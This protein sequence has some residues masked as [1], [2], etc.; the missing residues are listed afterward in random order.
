MSNECTRDQ[1]PFNGQMRTGTGPTLVYSIHDHY[2]C[3]I[4]NTSEMG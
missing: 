2:K 3:E 1:Y 4:V